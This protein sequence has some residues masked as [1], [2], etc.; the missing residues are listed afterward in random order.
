MVVYSR[1]TYR[2]IARPDVP[3]SH[4]RSIVIVLIVLAVGAAHLEP[5][6]AQGS[7]PTTTPSA[8]E[9]AD[10]S[11]S[12]RA[13]PAVWTVNEPGSLRVAI[14]PE[15][16]SLKQGDRVALFL[17]GSWVSHT[18][19][20]CRAFERPHTVRDFLYVRAPEADLSVTVRPYGLDGTP[21][22]LAREVRIAVDSG[23]VA[24]GQSLYVQY[25][26][27]HLP[28]R[29]SFLA[30]E[31]PLEVRYE[32]ETDQWHPVRSRPLV[33]TT[34]GPLRRIRATVPSVAQWGDTVSVHLTGRDQFGNPAPLP[35]EIS[36]RLREE[37]R[38]RTLWTGER[39]SISFDV[40]L[41][42]PGIRRV[43]VEGGPRGEVRSNPI[44]ITREAPDRR[45]F[46]G[47]LHSHSHLSKDGVGWN[48][49]RFARYHAN[50]DFYAR[51][52]HTSGDSTGTAGITDREWRLLQAQAER[53]HEPN[54]FVPILGYETS[55]PDR[56]YNVYFSTDRAPLHRQHEVEDVTTLWRHLEA[57]T[58]FT[59]PHHTGISWGAGS[60]WHP[61][62]PGDLRPLIEIYSGHGLSEL[63]DPDHRLAY[64]QVL[65]TKRWQDWLHAR[66]PH[67]PDACRESESG[68]VKQ[69]PYYARDAWALA[70][71]MGTIASSDDHSARPGQPEKGLTAVRA[72]AL[73]RPAIIG[74][75]RD[76][77]TYATTGQ[78]I[79]LDVRVGDRL[80]GRGFPANEVTEIDIEVH[81]TDSLAVVELLRLDSTTNQYEHRSWHP[82]GVS[83]HR[84]V[85]V[86]PE[87]ETA[88][89]YVRV[90]QT[91][92]VRGRPVMAWSSPIWLEH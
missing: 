90:R 2:P 5:V 66:A 10:R 83:F 50:L 18:F 89:Y 75:L 21:H 23:R 45:I 1:A 82:S 8:Y 78:R 33:T 70:S 13:E 60:E 64:D 63:Y 84:S 71:R 88:L 46:W 15:N 27:R 77:H 14:T 16:E 55:F 54:R 67:T 57:R 92:R 65:F 24:A 7:S 43:H 76:R 22:R 51:T 11:F 72:E 91:N 17:P 56:H 28:V 79:Y 53:Y 86:Q 58:A 32:D 80:A 44:K 37:E 48:P 61:D 62:P 40:Q 9:A 42:E 47:D 68:Q 85:S 38:A 4:S 74:A 26:T 30:Q 59:V 36:Y 41:G 73:N 49:Y 29:A 87:N 31:S 69:G 19:P 12:V 34:P 6:R 3:I 39:R 25:G 35:A 52:E 81:G 20:A